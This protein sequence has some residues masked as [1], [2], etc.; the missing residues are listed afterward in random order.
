MGGFEFW[1]LLAIIPGLFAFI[2]N[3]LPPP[4]AQIFNTWVK[5][6]VDYF[7]PYAF[8]DVPEFYGAGGNVVYDYVEEYLSSSTA[9][10]AQHV[11]LCRPKN[12]TQNTF[13]LAHNES[14]MKQFMGVNVWWTHSV[15]PRQGTNFSW[16]GDAPQDDKRTY[17]LKIR[18]SHKSRVLEP[19]VEHV[20]A[21]AKK[22]KEQTRDRLLY[23]NVK[24][25][26]HRYQQKLWESVLFKHPST[27]DTLAMNPELKAEIKEDLLDFTKGEEFYRRAG[28]AWKRGYLLYGPPG[29][30]KSS[31]IAAVANFLQY[32]IYDVELTEVASNSELRKLLI[33]T[34]DQSVIVIEDID[35]SLDLSERAKVRNKKEAKEKKPDADFK[36]PGR[37][38]EKSQV[39]LSGLLNFTDGLWSCCGS[40]RIII[41][42]TNHIEKLDPALLRSGRMDMHIH[43]SWCTF[44]A[45]QVLAYNNLGLEKH[46]L[47]PEVEKAIL[48]KAITPADVSEH[49]LKSKRNP[50]AALEGLIQVLHKTK[51]ASEIPVVS[52]EQD[53]KDDAISVT[54]EED[55]ALA[56]DGSIEVKTNAEIKELAAS[57]V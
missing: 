35:C 50:T 28:K 29:T 32:D 23:T 57:T 45:F 19:Y 30:G 27:F 48:D 5:T 8:L 26:G 1:T 46:D 24:N 47:F 33:Q 51:L 39:T 34:T 17:T 20:I 42:T 4:Y 41:F 52:L 37:E 31:M 13:S 3:V 40:E 9:L 2:H 56:D 38:D 49:L 16:P 53:D 44:T 25:T 21:T 7:S 18:K 6:L 43:L 54:A 10:A 12:A 36:R 11:S 15:S 14:I 55:S 22:V